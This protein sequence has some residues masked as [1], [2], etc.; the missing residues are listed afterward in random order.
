MN[1]DPKRETRLKAVRESYKVAEFRPVAAVQAP[2]IKVRAEQ[3]SLFGPRP[4]NR[5]RQ[6]QGVVNARKQRPVMDPIPPE[7]IPRIFEGDTAVLFA[8]GPSLTPA[9][10][11]EV[12]AAAAGS[13]LRLFG[14]NDAYRAVPVLDVHYAC[15]FAWWRIH[16]PEVAQCQIA[17][18]MWTQE[19]SMSKSQFPLLRRIAGNSSPGLSDKQNM[20]HF[21]NN[22][23]FQLINLAYLFGIKRMILCGYNMQVINKQK[24]FFGEHPQGLNRGG[25]YTGFA[26]NFETIKPAKHGIE[27][28]NAT[29]QT[30]LHCFPKM[31]LTD[32]LQKFC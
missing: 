10:A 13:R 17:E 30:A 25:G 3:P 27:I 16:Y 8:T 9:V 2:Q 6:A 20:I 21:G 22:S 28:I 4:K 29:P 32:A 12:M 18:G 7:T 31:D 15:D 1:P 24:H 11:A 19:P 14:C 5:P 23:G 26:A